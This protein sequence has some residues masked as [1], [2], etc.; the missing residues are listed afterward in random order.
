MTEPLSDQELADIEARCNELAQLA[1]LLR[2]TGPAG[3]PH[4]SP[5]AV[6][7]WFD[8]VCGRDMPRLTA[9]IRRLRAEVTYLR[10]LQT[11]NAESQ[12]ERLRTALRRIADAN[13]KTWFADEAARDMV[14]QARWALGDGD[15]LTKSSP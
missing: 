1:A 7:G 4:V 11:A 15:P 3:S 13:W 6:A 9:E 2:R 8:D 12:D 5:A 10:T 14:Q